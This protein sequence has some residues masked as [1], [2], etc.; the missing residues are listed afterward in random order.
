M[1]TVCLV[2]YLLTRTKQYRLF[3]G[4]TGTS[5][6]ILFIA[7]LFGILYFF[8]FVSG[9]E[10][11][12]MFISIRKIGPIMAG[13]L[14]GPLAGAGAAVVG[15][16][17]Q[18]LSGQ[19][20]AP[21]VILT[22][23]LDGFICGL[24]FLLNGKRLIR[25]IPALVLGVLLVG[26]DELLEILFYPEAISRILPAIDLAFLEVFVIA[27]GMALFTFIFQNVL[28]DKEQQTRAA[29]L[30]GQ[31][32]AARE[33]QEQ[34]L[35]EAPLDPGQ[36]R[37]AATLIP[38]IEVGGDFYDYGRVSE[39]SFYFCI[40]DVAGK[41]VSAA[42]VMASAVTL[43]RNALEYSSSPSEVLG[44]VNQGLI[45]SMREVQF[46]TI[47]FGVVNT[48]TWEVRYAN[49][50][51]LPPVIRSRQGAV[52]VPVFADIPAG[53]FEEN[54]YR[55][56]TFTLAD[57]EELILITDG[58]TECGEEGEMLGLDG[59]VSGL[60]AMDPPDPAETVREVTG[61]ATAYGGSGAV[62]DDLTVLAISRP[63]P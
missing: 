32:Q 28:S 16:G 56:D 57:G 48:G 1:A 51:H 21:V 41:G 38:M 50:G 42:F 44:F 35:P 54:T 27:V 7:V 18:T 60:A 53:T 12:E 5:R 49:A 30:E 46:V 26:M 62:S 11:D 24:V 10:T 31:I 3:T 9:V 29:R 37:V 36:A 22:E 34:Y 2:A 8:G 20:P 43:I 6:Y 47:F 25:V 39:S 14:A 40:G 63:E 45:R 61:I 23:L 33:I 19:G 55:E 13:L 59:L 15:M 17:L 58:V 52:L 4:T